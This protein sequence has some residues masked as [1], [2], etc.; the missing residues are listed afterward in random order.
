MEVPIK[1]FCFFPSLPNNS[2]DVRWSIDLRWQSPH[3]KWG[4]YDIQEGAPMRHPDKPDLEIDW[5]K[6]MAVNR[7]KVWQDKFC[8]MV[9][10]NP[11]VL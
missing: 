4:F 2:N 1:P 11:L 9:R 10:I 8:K 3:E 5:E 6:F 7:K